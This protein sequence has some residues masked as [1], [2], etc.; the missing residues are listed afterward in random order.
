MDAI[1]NFL[2]QTGFYLVQE[3]P[4]SLVMLAVSCVLLFLA[5][6]K[7][8]EPL[9]LLFRRRPP[10]RSSNRSRCASLCARDFRKRAAFRFQTS[11]EKPYPRENGPREGKGHSHSPVCPAATTRSV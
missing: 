7:K 8:F 11:T 9:L 1:V 2:Q 6:V 4:L 5:I 3:N 10:G